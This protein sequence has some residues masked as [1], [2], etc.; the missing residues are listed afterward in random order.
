MGKLE[1][2]FRTDQTHHIKLSGMNEVTATPSGQ[3]IPV[4]VY[5]DFGAGAIYF[6]FYISDDV[7]VFQTCVDL[8]ADSS[9]FPALVAAAPQLTLQMPTFGNVPVSSASLQFCGRVFFYLE[10]SITSEQ[11]SS[12]CAFA[13]DRALYIQVF[14]P[15]WERQRESQEHPLAFISHDWR[16]KDSI[17]EPLA[18]EL[19]RRNVPV[20]YSEYSLHV[21]DSLRESIERGLRECQRCVIVLTPHYLSNPG[22]TKTEFTSMFTRELLDD[23]RVILPLW[24]GVTKRDVF[25]YSPS[26]ADRVALMWDTGVQNVALRLAAEIRKAG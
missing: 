21:G 2:Y 11:L 1:D 10:S 20:W 26:L 15:E 18:R 8:I 6:A 4:G 17:A 3:R 13:H 9:L 19:V 5:Q 14:G 16:D 12:L 23:S 7:D 24:A 22:W 25:E